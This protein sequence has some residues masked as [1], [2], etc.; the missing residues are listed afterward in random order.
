MWCGF[1]FTKALSPE[2]PFEPLGREPED[3][4]G[5]RAYPQDAPKRRIE[6][7]IYPTFVKR[8]DFDRPRETFDLTNKLVV[9]TYP[10]CGT[11][12]MQQICL[13]ISTGGD[14]SKVTDVFR[15]GPW[16]EPVTAL[17]GR[18]L[19]EIKP[20]DGGSFVVWKTH[21]AATH[22]PWRS[23]GEGGKVI[24]VT[25]NP[26]DCAVSYYHHCCDATD[27]PFG[28]DWDFF[29]R[30]VFLEGLCEFGD[31]WEWHAGHYKAYQEQQARGDKSTLWISFEEMKGN[32][33]AATQTVCSFLDVEPTDQLLE[34]VTEGSDFQAMKQQFAQLEKDRA[35]KGEWFKK[36]HIR[37]G[38]SGAWRKVFTE[39]QTELVLRIH[40]ERCAQYGLPEELFDLA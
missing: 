38:K 34:S 14:R 12:W 31:F 19:D 30:K 1:D 18:S 33:L 11:T 28:G 4:E 7:C 20:I 13:L 5:F 6:G 40:K 23:R 32:P 3:G 26:C 16:I 24:I 35:A 17:S 29:L 22:L 9:C 21:A 2:A 15:Q 36:N 39:E 8:E 37:Q 10:K 27:H 25:R